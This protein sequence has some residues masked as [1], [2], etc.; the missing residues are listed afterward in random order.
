MLWQSIVPCAANL[1]SLSIHTTFVELSLTGPSPWRSFLHLSSLTIGSYVR[2][3]ARF[4]E[5]LQQMRQLTSLTFTVASDRDKSGFLESMP[6]L[7]GLRSLSL[8]YVGIPGISYEI[9]KRL[10]VLSQLT[11]LCLSDLLEDQ[12]LRLPKELVDLCLFS[13][14]SFPEDLSEQLAALTDLTSLKM[15]SYEELHLF[16]SDGMRPIRLSTNSGS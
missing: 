5:A 4:F 6:S 15:H 10:S 16:H 2:R 8:S 11:R 12:P 7:T 14:Y 9:T 13:K 1:Q 3:D